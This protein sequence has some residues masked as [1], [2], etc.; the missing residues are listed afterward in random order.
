VS[1]PDPVLVVLPRPSWSA[2][3]GSSDPAV[4]R[5]LDS[6]VQVDTCL[7]AAVRTV[8]GVVDD[9]V[10]SVHLDA[11]EATADRWAAEDD[12]HVAVRTVPVDLGR[13]GGMP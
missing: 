9:L 12:A 8:D 1:D 3:V 11:A 2:L 10:V 6:L 4:R 7:H 13:P 5:A